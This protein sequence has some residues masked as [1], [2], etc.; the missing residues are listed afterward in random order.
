VAAAVVEFCCGRI[1]VTNVPLDV[2]EAGPLFKAVV[3]NVARMEW[4]L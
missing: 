3:M 1:G 2:F 4:A